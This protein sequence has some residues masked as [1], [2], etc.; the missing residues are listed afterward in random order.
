MKCRSLS[1]L[2]AIK[3]DLNILDYTCQEVLGECSF[4]LY[5]AK[6]QLPDEG[7][8][9]R[10]RKLNEIRVNLRKTQFKYDHYDQGGKYISI[11]TGRMYTI[12]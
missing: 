2:L 12:R 11:K 5:Q 4:R 9:E 1:E 8:E 6:G 3:P 7:G 10:W